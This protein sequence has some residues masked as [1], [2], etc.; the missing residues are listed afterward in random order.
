MK[1][2]Y[3]LFTL[4][5]FVLAQHDDH[6]HDGHGH[7]GIPKIGII[8]GK[9]INSSNEEPIEYAT[10]SIYQSDS[11]ELIGGGITDVDGYFNI[12]RIPT[13]HFF[14]VV[15]FIGYG[16]EII[17][18]VHLN[19]ELG[20]KRD[21]GTLSL[22]YKAIQADE[23]RVID[24]ISHIE[25][26]TDKLVYNATD[27][28]LS[29]TS[30]SA[31]DLLK[32]VPMVTI[33]QEGEISLRGNSNVKILINGRENRGDGVD[34]ISSDF[35]D[36]VEVITSPSAEYDP[37]GMAGIINIILKKGDYEGV[38]GN[39]KVNGRLGEYG[40]FSNMNGLSTFINYKKGK[41]N[42][43]SAIS[44]SNKLRYKWAERSAI[45]SY[46]LSEDASSTDVPDST[47]GYA[48]S[49]INDK[50][51]FV[52]M[53]KLGSDYSF[54]NNLSI[55]TEIVYFKHLTDAENNKDNYNIDTYNSESNQNE[56]IETT[57]TEEHDANDNYDLEIAFEMVK[58]FSDSEDEHEL[59]FN[60][61][62]DIE[63]D[64]E[65]ET[66]IIS[67]N[68]NDESNLFEDYKSIEYK[69]IYRFPLSENSKLSVGYDAKISDNEE[70]LKFSY[71]DENYTNTYPGTIDFTYDRSIH[72]TFIA[73]DSKL[74]DKFSIKPSIRFEYVQRSIYFDKTIPNLI[75]DGEFVYFD[76]LNAT[77]EEPLDT[78][79]LSYYPNLNISY[80]IIG[81]KS[82]QLGISRRVNRPGSGRHGGG[83]RQI[84]PFPRDIYNDDF[85]FIGDP[86]LKP[87]Y[88]NQ[89]ELSYNTPIPMGFMRLSTFYHILEDA[90]TWY[91]DDRFEDV[92]VI[93]FKNAAGA[94]EYGI[95]FYGMII[96]QVLGGNI[97]KTILEDPSASYELND[98]S[99]FYNLFM[100]ITL[101]EDMIKIFDFEFGL[102]WMK[103]TNSGG[104]MFGENGTAW[105]DLGASKKI[106]NN[107]LVLSFG[108]DNLFDVGGFQANILKPLDTG[109]ILDGYQTA[110]EQTYV[111]TGSGGRTYSLSLKYNFGQIQNKNNKY[112]NKD[113]DHD[114][115]G[116]MDMGY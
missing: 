30:G 8:T 111:N 87:E 10:V 3:I 26:E 97:N 102:Y 1:K 93:T 49:S 18:D 64:E 107:R 48:Y 9:V 14:V 27:E 104:S 37:E 51:R 98:E 69:L 72:S 83:S 65:I 116:G 105:T 21:L 35:I 47:N 73:Y 45:T 62:L 13:G 22:T 110:F 85:I 63:K 34:H 44:I 41:L 88:S 80:N 81:K 25:F 42:L 101:P 82:I 61:S 108:I 29:S 17:K 20:I 70:I 60:L 94:T 115:G 86:F 89:Y 103:M 99:T 33:D 2:I 54:E 90:I 59:S 109:D 56:I 52:N 38:N 50:P 55:N 53:F 11:E 77:D 106:M 112:G 19:R 95:S 12:D 40:N 66:R 23:V 67:G 74:N 31:E 92:D 68:T 46:Y 71:S 32:K 57:K 4:L 58:D 113:H 84:R 96:G 39:V 36:R 6:G 15:E 5:S 7:G 28:I 16:R 100:Q 78:D 79:Y 114:G 91:D 75:E 43:Y 24:K 76:L